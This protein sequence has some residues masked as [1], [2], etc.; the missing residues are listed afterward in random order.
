MADRGN[1]SQP[2]PEAVPTRSRRRSAALWGA[3]G[4]LAF[5]AVSQGY[6]LLGGELPFRYVGLFPLAVA[7]GTALATTAYAFERRLLR[8]E[9]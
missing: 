5:L 3:V 9:R 2:A 7:V 1:G 8:W 4:A 6:L